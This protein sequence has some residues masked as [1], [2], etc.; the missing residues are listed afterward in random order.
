ML[1]NL[2]L[3]QKG[4]NYYVDSREVAAFI[5]KQHKNLLRDISGY[6]SY[7]KKSIELTFELN[8]Y[9]LE[10]SYFDSRRRALPRYLLTKAGCEICAN[11][12]SGERGVLFTVAYVTKFNTMEKHL[13][14]E[15][16]A[17][18]KDLNKPR[19]NE[20]NSAVK[21][22]L[23]G[24]SR[25]YTKPDSVMKFLR[26]VYEP[27]GIE[28]LPFHETDYYGYYTVTEIASKIGIYSDTGR[29]HGHAVSAIISS[30]NNYA[31]HALAIPYGL[32]GATIRYDSF[33]IESVWNWLVENKFPST[34][35]YLDFDYH[36][37][38]H[39]QLSLHNNDFVLKQND[40]LT[41][42]ELDEMCS[43]FDNCDK[44]PG[45]FTCYEM[46]Q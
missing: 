11:K 40:D 16:E 24:M 15:Q 17:K 38:Y 14:A 33:I 10:S 9:F 3:I 46:D 1:N 18:M 23:S 2:T 34:V 8:D 43:K 6:I 27:L 37:H 4:N 28:V 35:P 41:V 32:V 5:G 31:S 25:C 45:R 19:L 26:G 29:P 44:C 42:E 39:R 30:L 36:I 13:R 20:F 21:N 22:V 12:L 7:M